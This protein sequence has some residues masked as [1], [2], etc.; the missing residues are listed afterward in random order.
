MHI[1]TLLLMV[2]VVYIGLQWSA[3]RRMRN[4]WRLAATFPVIAM[5]AALA[6]FVIGMFTNASLATV[7]LV[8]GLPLATLYLV[9][10]LPLHWFV[11]RH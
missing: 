1:E 7:W 11:S 2:P 3:L 4:G 6:L 5:L 9:C 10:L 8:L